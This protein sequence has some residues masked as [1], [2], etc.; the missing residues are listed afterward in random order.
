MALPLLLRMPAA[1]AIGLF[2]LTAMHPSWW[3][4]AFGDALP[5]ISSGSQPVSPPLGPLWATVLLSA[6]AYAYLLTT[7]RNNGIDWRSAL[8]RSFMVLLVG[9]L[10]ALIVSLLGLAWVVRLSENENSPKAGR[11]QPCRRHHS[12][13]RLVSGSRRILPTLGRPSHH[14]PLTRTRWRKDMWL[15]GWNAHFRKPND[16]DRRCCGVSPIARFG[17]ETPY[18]RWQ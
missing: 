11:P 16:L 3:H 2:M 13:S 10:H 15:K 1:A 5:D 6:A 18:M 14:A 7:A 12:N 4:A 17:V 8:G 9:A